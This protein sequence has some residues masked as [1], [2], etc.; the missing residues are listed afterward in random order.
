M[1][2]IACSVALP[3]ACGSA[4]A[5][6]SGAASATRRPSRWEQ[7]LTLV[8]IIGKQACALAVVDRGLD[9]L[10]I[11]I[12]MVPRRKVALIF[13]GV[14]LNLTLHGKRI[15]D[16]SLYGALVVMVLVTTVGGPSA[17]RFSFA[18]GTRSGAQ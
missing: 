15:V 9:R 10:S 3:P 7:R 5:E 11:A 1:A 13:A 14:G 6:A 2:P 8:A 16:D 4:S 18:R 12:G 17:L